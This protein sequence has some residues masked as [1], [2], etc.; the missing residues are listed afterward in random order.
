MKA[1]LGKRAVVVGAGIGG[2]AATAALA[3][4]FESVIV[5]DRDVLPEANAARMGVGHGAHT[6]QLLKAG[7]LSLERLLP[8]VT[9]QFYAAG[10]V[11]MRVGRDVK[12]FDFGGWMDACD[13]GFSVTSLS[14]PAYEGILRARATA[15]PGVELRAET[16]VKRFVVEDGRC[17]GVELEDGSSIAADL[18]VDATGMTGPLVRQL[19]EDGHAEFE[20]EDVKINVAY[21]TAK[22][23]RTEQHRHTQTGYFF[24]PGPPGKQFG[25]LLPIEDNQWILSVGA[26][27]KESPP[28]TIEELRS[29]A[30]A[31]D[32]SVYERISEAEPTSEIR[33]FRKISATRRKFWEAA[34]WPEALIPIGDA[35]SSVNPTYGQGMT[36]AACEAEALADILHRRTESRAS[37]EGV[38]REYLLIAAEISG[39]AWSLSINSDYVYP[40]TEGERPANFAMT[41]AMA[42]TLR[43][44]ADDEMVFR[45]M[46]YRLVHMVDSADALREGPLAIRFFSALQG[47]MA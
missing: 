20:T 38:A 32:A 14:R 19:T 9:Q 41:R 11:E 3:R 7:E 42:A 1:K 10:A 36:V 13:A 26:R 33:T 22:F 27:G 37:L 5:L 21:S 12:V 34:R 40:E 16:G 18:V 29:Y 28:K 45:I 25:F 46:R 2:L 35:M 15:L 8:G 4:A 30:Q 39:R 43:K 47:S 17:T 24:L 31:F 44:L 23:R 6:H